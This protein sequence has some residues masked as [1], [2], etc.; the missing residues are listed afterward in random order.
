MTFNKILFISTFIFVISGCATTSDTYDKDYS[1]E[2]FLV[3]DLYVKTE[4]Q[5]K[6]LINRLNN[7]SNKSDTFIDLQKNYSIPVNGKP[8]GS[9]R[10]YWTSSFDEIPQFGNKIFS[11]KEGQYLKKALNTTW[12]YR[13]VYL[14]KKVSKAQYSHLKNDYNNQIL[15]RISAYEVNYIS[16]Y[17]QQL[18]MAPKHIETYVQPYNK[19]QSCKILMSYREGA[20]K[21]FKDPS[22]KVFWDGSCKGGYASGLGREIE[23]ADMIDKWA[24]AIYKNKRPTYYIV[25]NLLSNSVSEGIDE[26]D[27]SNENY[28]VF[29]KITEK[30]NDIDV[31]TYA[32]SFSPKKNVGVF[33][34]T[35]PFWN[36]SYKYEKKYPNFRYSYVNTK[37][38]DT[39]N[40]NFQFFIE[41]QNGKNGWGIDQYKNGSI[42]TGEY[43]NNKGTP[44][45][46]PPKYNKKAKMIYNEVYRAQQKAF[47]AQEYAQQVK[48]QYLKRICKEKVKVN[49]MDNGDYKEI[50]S[51]K[52]DLVILQKIYNKLDKISKEKI[53]RLNK[54]RFTAQQQEAEKY[55][56]K[57][58]AMEQSKLL[59]IQ[60]H[61]MAVESQ[62]Q[63]DHMQ[64]GWKN[65]NEQIN[66]ITPKTYN[67]N[68]Y[69]Y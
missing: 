50:C 24:I 3:R 21:W 5:A 13:L 29:T 19:K 6:E 45:T 18:K 61:N 12:G 8:A 58:L 4:T 63:S 62:A 54:Q 16:E 65:L 2:Q 34:I 14:E 67:V 33:S 10:Y 46:L 25:N 22:Y 56:K 37:E 27:G 23:S 42:A 59:E 38:N 15:E 69:S 1:N 11:L 60:R 40:Y 68:V 43:I 32:G 35:S 53:E 64:Q 48:K 9:I 17:E 49:F 20:T 31:I 41:N 30:Q 7:S 47:K 26:L 66:N 55:R 57:K 36:G 51:N 28:T 52:K 39:S 44:L